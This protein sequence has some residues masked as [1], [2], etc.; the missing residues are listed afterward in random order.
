MEAVGNSTRVR[1]R[2]VLGYFYLS[3]CTINHQLSY[4]QTTHGRNRL[5]TDVVCAAD[6]TCMCIVRERAESTIH[7]MLLISQMMYM[8]VDGSLTPIKADA[9]AYDRE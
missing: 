1:H 9:L 7:S 8:N 2:C 4:E 5:Q 6:I 3:D